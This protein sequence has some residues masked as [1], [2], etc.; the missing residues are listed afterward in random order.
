MD[1]F[2]MITPYEQNFG[3]DYQR[4]MVSLGHEM[5]RI[6]RHFGVNIIY[7]VVGD[8]AANLITALDRDGLAVSPASNEMHAGF[9]PRAQAELEGIGFCLTT[10][11]VGSLPCVTAAALAKTEGL[12]VVFISGAP[13]EDEVH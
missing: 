5:R 6:I 12:P 1:T 13:G 11:T 7:G 3:A 9:C 2:R 4:S 10:Y 8:F